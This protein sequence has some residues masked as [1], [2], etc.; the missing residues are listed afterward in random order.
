[1]VCRLVFL[2]GDISPL[3]VLTHVPVLCEDHDIPY[4]YVPSKEVRAC[5]LTPCLSCNTHVPVLCEDHHI[6]YVYVPSKEVRARSLM[7]CLCCISISNSSFWCRT[8]QAQA[9]PSGQRAA[10]W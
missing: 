3:D 10:S 5:S 9:R 1:M 6:P 4:V 7:P 8:S 2:A